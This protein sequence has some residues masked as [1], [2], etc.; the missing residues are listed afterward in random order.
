MAHTPSEVPKSETYTGPSVI[1]SP[2][3][4]NLDSALVL[5]IEDNA[6]MRE[7]I[8]AAIPAPWE[9]VEAANGT[10]GIQKAREIVPDLIISDLMMPGKDGYEVCEILKSEE[11]TAHIPIILLTGK[12]T[13]ESK[14][15]GL[16]TGADDYLVK[17]FHTAELLVRVENLIESRRMLRDR[18]S[19]EAPSSETEPNAH[20]APPDRDFLNR[21]LGVLNEHLSDES[22]TV[23]DLAGNLFISRVQLHRKLKAIADKNATEFIRDYRLERAMVKLQ[24]RE[25]LVYEVAYQVGFRSEKHFSRAFKEKFGVSPS[26]V[27]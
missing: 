27:V 9:V 23:E 6:D 15:K 21:L 12:T 18:F 16:R 26:Q 4:A 22:F 5:L 8:R 19:P 17:P 24:N 3:P 2:E 14:L 1:R 10:E 25:G 13:M 20:L 7:F 11:L